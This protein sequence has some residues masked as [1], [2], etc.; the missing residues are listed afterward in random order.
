M[1]RSLYREAQ[2]IKGS[3]EYRRRIDK[4]YVGNRM[5]SLVEMKRVYSYFMGN[6]KGAAQ[7]LDQLKTSYPEART[8]RGKL[9]EWNFDGDRIFE[10]FILT[11][12]FF[13]LKCSKQKITSFAELSAKVSPY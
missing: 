3:E 13:A 4:K 9:I 11:N 10:E 5:T 2:S 8:M 12:E 1:K 6:T 7:F